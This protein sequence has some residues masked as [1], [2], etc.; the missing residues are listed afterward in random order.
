MGADG[1]VAGEPVSL[2]ANSPFRVASHGELPNPWAMAFEPGSGRLFVTQQDGEL[3][4]YDPATGQRNPVSGTPE[5]VYENQGG[6]GDIAFAPDYASSGTIYLSW[7]QDAGNDMTVAAVGRGQ[8]DCADSGACSITGFSEI[9][10]QSRPA[11]KKGHYSHRIAFS[12]DGRYLFVASGDRQEQTPA[13][14]LSNNLGSIVRLTLDGRAA[15]GNPFAD[16]GGATQ[17]I[18]SYGH[19]NILGL[20][21]APDGQ[22]WEVEHGP[23][24]GDEL[25]LVQRGA[26]YGW[27]VRSNGVNYN[28]SNIPNHTADDGFTKPAAYWTPVI[29]P[30]DMAFYTGDM[31][32]DWNGDLLIANLKVKSISRV[33]VDGDSAQEVARYDFPNRLRDIA[34]GPDGA[35]W[36]IEDEE[37]G[38]LLRLTPKS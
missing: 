36:V 10:R 35:I 24:G 14:D 18:W 21:F 13:Q 23:K 27:P 28:D 32:G 17:Q 8:L 3:L 31:F 19:R 29:A 38:R 34:V 4:V 26:N 9:W 7:A 16:R 30:G 15:P 11:E 1:V 12:P 33:T 6:L 25:N 5:V 2:A 37:N 22:L 20:A